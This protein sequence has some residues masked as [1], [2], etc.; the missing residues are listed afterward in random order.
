MGETHTKG[1]DHR[2]CFK[3]DGFVEAAT[4]IQSVRVAM[5]R[6]FEDWRLMSVS[7]VLIPARI[8]HFDHAGS[9]MHALLER[10]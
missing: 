3:W 6:T 1:G 9:S 8:H 10:S 5:A 4:A 2:P 7:V